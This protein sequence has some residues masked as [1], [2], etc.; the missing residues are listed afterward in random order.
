ME[1]C[2]LIP[3]DGKSSAD[4][5]DWAM[6]NSTGDPNRDFS[7]TAANAIDQLRETVIAKSGREILSTDTDLEPNFHAPRAYY[8]DKKDILYIPA[9]VLQEWAGEA[10]KTLTIVKELI[11]QELLISASSKN[12]MNTTIPGKGDIRHYRISLSD[13]IGSAEED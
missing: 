1:E 8:S 10:E 13:L 12:R 3:A 5:V 4:V 6:S 9:D 11:R 7:N 2:E